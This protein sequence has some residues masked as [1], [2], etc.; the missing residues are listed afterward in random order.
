MIKDNNGVI[1]N[2]DVWG[3]KKLAYPIDKQE[4]AVYVAF[5]LDLPGA[6][7]AKISNGLNINKEILRYLLVKEDERIKAA[8]AEA[9]SETKEEVSETDEQ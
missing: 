6:A 7:V 4:F 2:Q 9:G 8:R 5:E 3:K 1:K